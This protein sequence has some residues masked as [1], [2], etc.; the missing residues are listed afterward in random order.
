[1][2]ET[3]ITIIAILIS[4]IISVLFGWSDTMHYYYKYQGTGKEKI[5]FTY[6]HEI[7]SAIRL[8]A[9]LPIWYIFWSF[10]GWW[11]ILGIIATMS[12]FP[13]FHDGMYYTMT[14]VYTKKHYPKRWTDMTK[15]KKLST[16]F[17]KSKYKIVNKIKYFIL[18]NRISFTWNVRLAGL[19]IGTI[20]ILEMILKLHF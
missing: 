3:I 7:W 18:T 8:L 17:K 16:T 12:I 20:L 2:Y 10:F 1:M 14:N 11:S 15:S 4:S 13:F 5:I 9:L 19:I 6:E